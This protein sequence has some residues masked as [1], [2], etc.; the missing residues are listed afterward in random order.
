[1]CTVID[2]NTIPCVFNGNNS[3]HK[4]FKPILD[5]I[6]KGKGKLVFGGKTYSNELSRLPTYLKLINEL[7][8]AGKVVKVDNEKIDKK[9]NEIISDLKRRGITQNDKSYNDAHIVAIVF[10]SKV[11]IVT[12][13]DKHSYGFLRESRYY[14]KTTDR[15]LIYTR[16]K[17]I[18][19]IKNVKY[20]GKCCI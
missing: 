19:L 20:H 13:L 6:T 1:M 7:N 5:W 10:V 3:D 4:D 15:P 17:N 11:K 2:M 14:D 12:S 9:E 8:T 16:S 18:T